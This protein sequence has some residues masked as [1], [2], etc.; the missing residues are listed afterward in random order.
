MSSRKK[1]RTS[2]SAIASFHFKLDAKAARRI[3]ATLT[4]AG[5]KMLAHKQRL[6]VR[7]SLKLT[8]GKARPRTYASTLV[9]T[10]SAPTTVHVQSP[11]TA[12]RLP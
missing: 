12:L 10:R 5:R 3:T 11:R 4:P 8:V 1:K 7:A 6:L 2:S 9:V